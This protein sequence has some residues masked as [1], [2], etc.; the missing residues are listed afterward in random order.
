MVKSAKKAEKTEKVTKTVEKTEKTERKANYVDA[1]EKAVEIVSESRETNLTVIVL[2]NT[3]D[4][5]D[6]KWTNR[7]YEVKTEI[8][9]V[10]TLEIDGNYLKINDNMRNLMSDFFTTNNDGIVVKKANGEK[11]ASYIVKDGEITDYDFESH[12]MTVINGRKGR[13][14]LT[15]KINGL[16]AEDKAKVLELIDN[17]S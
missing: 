10:R 7:E 11:I 5:Y 6:E 16:S 9:G 13:K 17:L 2:R 1:C 3:R 14:S 12:N 4:K 8:D 15:G